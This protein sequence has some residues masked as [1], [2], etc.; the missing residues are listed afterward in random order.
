MKPTS[1]GVVIVAAFF[2]VLGVRPA[3]AQ[4]DLGGMWAPI[5][6]ED[7]LERV[8]GPEI[9]DYSGL[10]INDAARMRADSWMSSLLTLPEHQCK[11][12]PST[13]GFRGVG[14]LRITAD[15]DRATQA[16]I[17]L[18]TH[19]QWQEQEREIW[20]DGRPHPPEYAPHTWQGFSTG[21]WEGNV[22]VVTTT[23]L[24]AGWI[25]RNGLA[26]TD[27]ATM[28]ERFIRHGNYLTHIYM[29]EDPSYLTEPLIKTNG[30][31]LTLNPAMPPYPC[32]PAVEVP[33][34]KGE[35]PHYL[36]GENPFLGDYAKKNNLP[37]QEGR[38]GADTALPESI[39][40][41]FKPQ[42]TQSPKPRA[43]SPSAS[44]S[45]DVKSMHVQG[46]VWMLVGSGVNAAAQI[47]DDGVLIVDTMTD[48]QADKLIAEV[49]KIAGDKPIRWIINTHVHAD[50]TGG[51]EKVAKAGQS[52]VGGNFA[53]QV[54]QAAANSAQIIAHENVLKR[55]S[56][57][58]GN[59]K[60][61]PTVALP[62]DTF[63]NE[64]N[65][66]YF[67][68]EAVQILYQP[69]A[70]TDGDVIVFFRK[71]DVVVAGDVFNTLTFPVIDPSGSLNGIV[72]SLNRILDITVPKDKQEGGTYVIPGHGR[73]TDEAD[74]V[75]YR[76]MMTIIRDR[77][78]DAIKKGRTLEQVKAA[79]L[80]RDYEGR[81]G[82]TQGAWTTDK[83]LE[84][85]YRSLKE[86]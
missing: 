80:L 64:E 17:K 75:E 74:V 18:N 72:A 68:G 66:L 27:R 31:A 37:L 82:A 84:A 55:M 11:P 5:F 33:H 9:G 76:D 24:K 15:V 65:E 54:G 51:N 34:D 13:Y 26:I 61:V 4:V 16:T 43:Q 62:T 10:P 35:V 12:H 46:N 3:S 42:S 1:V 44:Q 28:T 21:R 70:H 20:M 63:F 73:L 2:G 41:G 81:F 29:I 40:P 83:F 49:K 69:D 38:G 7:Q 78:A 56:E 45:S 25:R 30:F 58:E 77:L 14:N 50:H 19:I 52:V 57:T 53:A 79:G 32:H 6:H 36:P 86:K 48:S 8:P 23:H 67:N 59:A 47:G 71:S 60:P 85:A 39:K 22:L